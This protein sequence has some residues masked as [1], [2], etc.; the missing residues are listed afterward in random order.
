MATKKT[1]KEEL[2]IFEVKKWIDKICKVR[3][4]ELTYKELKLEDDVNAKATLEGLNKQI[5][6]VDFSFK[7]LTSLLREYVP[8]TPAEI[9]QKEK[10]KNKKKEKALDKQNKKN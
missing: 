3:T 7:E 10:A 4:L 6:E 9:A 1:V 2:S 8:L 5:A